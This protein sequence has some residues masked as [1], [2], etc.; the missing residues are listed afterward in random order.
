LSLDKLSHHFSAVETGYSKSLVVGSL[1]MMAGLVLTGAATVV[2]GEMNNGT[3][4]G[5]FISH[6]GFSLAVGAGICLNRVA[7][8]EEPGPSLLSTFFTV[9]LASLVGLSLAWGLAIYFDV[10]YFAEVSAGLLTLAGA[11]F[12]LGHHGRYSTTEREAVR[13]LTRTARLEQDGAARDLVLALI[14]ASPEA[15]IA[16][17]DDGLTTPQFGTTP[18]FA[19]SNYFPAAVVAVCEQDDGPTPNQIVETLVSTSE[20]FEKRGDGEDA[21]V[22]QTRADELA[23]EFDIDRPGD[24]WEG[25]THDGGTTNETDTGDTSNASGNDYTESTATTED[26]SPAGDDGSVTNEPDEGDK[27]TTKTT[28]PGETGKTSDRQTR[29]E[30]RAE[31][32]RLDTETD[33]KPYPNGNVVNQNGDYHVNQYVS[34]FGSWEA[35]LEAAGIRV[36]ERLRDE[37]RRVSDE[38][39]EIPT[40]GQFR[41]HGRVSVPTLE[42]YLGSWQE[43]KPPVAVVE[44]DSTT[45]KELITALRRSNDDVDPETEHLASRVE[46]DIDNYVYEFG[47]WREALLAADIDV[48]PHLCGELSQL[49]EQ[50]PVLPD[51]SELERRSQFNYDDYTDE[52]GS[53][54]TALEAAGISVEDRLL[55]EIR[56]VSDELGEIPTESDMNRRGRVSP[57]AIGQ[58]LGSW[59]NAVERI[60]PVSSGGETESDDTDSSHIQDTDTGADTT[61]DT[62]NKDPTDGPDRANLTA[63]IRRLD[64]GTT[65]FPYGNEIGQRGEY[66]LSEYTDEF[67]SWK[68]A[69]ETADIDIE[70]RLVEEIRRVRDKIGELPSQTQMNAH[71]RVS[72]ATCARYLGAW[73]EAK[74]RAGSVTQS[75]ESEDPPPGGLRTDRDTND[76]ATS[77]VPDGLATATDIPSDGSLTEPILIRIDDELNA[78]SHLSAAFQVTD[79]LG[80]SFRFDVHEQHASGIGWQTNEWYLVNG[81]RGRRGWGAEQRLTTGSSLRVKTFGS[82]R[83]ELKTLVERLEADEWLSTTEGTVEADDADETPQGGSGGD[84]NGRKGSADE[85]T[86]DELST[87]DDD[88]NALIDE[89]DDMA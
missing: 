66:T 77:V 89:L 83:P 62:D 48:E 47:S 19:E 55:D 1:V 64:D 7:D 42:R 50:T 39:G 70:T 22:C 2:F 75:V 35:A 33:G 32:Q 3:Y 69:L 59:S 73:S 43:A 20:R 17:A 28:E 29:S 18:F 46:H 82:T 13:S 27:E 57:E 21:T 26:D 9:Y 5:L 45:R 31:I 25:D 76:E 88:L 61:D 58:H 30:M 65:L 40:K 10:P 56:R 71:G 8:N 78:E 6:F 38:L 80:E 36:E 85:D 54:G 67:G 68:A 16:E 86:D 84:S 74:S 53:W 14:A 41:D 52:F 51:E 4:L 23:A 44:S 37:I 12:V 81:V 79:A 15:A 49:D 60:D 72:S 87:G 63:E 34:E 24:E 11:R